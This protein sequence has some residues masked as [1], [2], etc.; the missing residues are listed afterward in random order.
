MSVYLVV[1]AVLAVIL[2]HHQVVYCF[3]YF[4]IQY[5]LMWVENYYGVFNSVVFLYRVR[6]TINSLSLS[7]SLSVRV[8]SDSD[9]SSAYGSDA[10]RSPKS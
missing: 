8:D 9:S 1:Q 4:H 5:A 3:F 6:H 7:L 10:G 2:G